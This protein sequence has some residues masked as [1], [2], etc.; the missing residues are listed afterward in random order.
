MNAIKSNIE[1]GRSPPPQMIGSILLYF[2]RNQ[3]DR[4]DPR[5]SPSTPATP[6]I[7]PNAVNTLRWIGIGS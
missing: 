4:P 5:V 1:D 2:G 6:I 3:Y 7:K